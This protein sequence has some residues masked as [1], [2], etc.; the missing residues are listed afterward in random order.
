MTSY[1][2]IP[3]ALHGQAL[4]SGDA[5]AFRFLPRGDIAQEIVL[6]YRQVFD[7][8]LAR[9]AL[10]GAFQVKGKV[11]PMIYDPSLEF[12]VSFFA[13]VYAGGIPSPLRIPNSRN[14]ARYT[15]F[16]GRVLE[17]TGADY[18]A[19]SQAQITQL[20][21]LMPDTKFIDLS[22][23]PAVDVLPAS[24]APQIDEAQTFLMQFTSG[25][26][27]DPKGIKI[28]HANLA[29]NASAMLAGKLFTPGKP[30]V[31]WMPHYHDMG[32]IASI[33]V[34]MLHGSES[35]LMSPLS[36]MRKPECWLS[37]ISHYTA[38]S[39]G[40]P[41]FAYQ[42]VLDSVSSNQ[43]EGLNLSCWTT[44]YCGSEP[45][46]AKTMLDFANFIEPT[47][48]T[49]QSLFPCYGMAEATLLLTG[50][51]GIKVHQSALSHGKDVVC[52]GVS[53]DETRV[54]IIESETGDV[55]AEG[56]VGEIHITGPS[57]SV[58][59]PAGYATGDLGFY[60]DG[61]LYVCGRSKEQII[62]R[63]ENYWPQDIEQIAIEE[64]AEGSAS[65][66]AAFSVEESD[67]ERLIVLVGTRAKNVQ[68]DEAAQLLQRIRARITEEFGISPWQ[69]QLVPA[70]EIAKTSSGKIQRTA[71]S[72]LWRT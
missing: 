19:A 44:A 64:L 12:V 11:V 58:G 16:L 46:R 18:V 7:Q 2:N 59:L 43:L 66:C 65:S 20:Q 10:L 40:G 60:A 56:E 52:V 3:V 45:I 25:S 35:I 39:S 13:V 69:L 28:S 38:S 6:T 8:V 61:E 31:S 23:A 53:C 42:L 4:S 57:V 5:V 67:T 9:A 34:P 33:A 14:V 41:N 24:S 48:F 62:I 72:A 22:I 15:D 32:L 29:A 1:P 50:R 26:T 27:G 71:C 54:E 47:G 36:F 21:K 51:H 68:Q 30:H 17:I 37:A 49:E 63:G 70:R 55:C